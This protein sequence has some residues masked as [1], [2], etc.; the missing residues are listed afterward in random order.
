MYD[1]CSGII[2]CRDGSDEMDCPPTDHGD[3]DA[4]GM[5]PDELQSSLSSN[6]SQTGDAKP[7][8]PSQQHV[9]TADVAQSDVHGQVLNKSHGKGTAAADDSYGG[10]VVD[11]KTDTA[12]GDDAGDMEEH[13]HR[14]SGSVPAGRLAHSYSDGN[15]ADR[16]YKEKEKYSAGQSREQDPV[17]DTGKS[18]GR[19]PETEQRA[20]QKTPGGKVTEVGK[21]VKDGV[22]PASSDDTVSQQGNLLLSGMVDNSDEPKHD[23]GTRPRYPAVETGRNAEVE[24]DRNGG[25]KMGGEYRKVTRPKPLFGGVE[26]SSHSVDETDKPG[27]F[28]CT[29]K[30]H[31]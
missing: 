13:L 19:V 20:R 29:S 14:L 17:S 23:I 26:K 4:A 3:S 25:G 5:Q 10:V 1:R 21:V 9:D 8:S 27:M 24:L 6:L 30:N 15:S 2:Q 11:G 22:R 7:N 12:A 28:Y 31:I 16:T 18:V